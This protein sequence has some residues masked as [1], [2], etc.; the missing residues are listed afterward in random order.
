MEDLSSRS[1]ERTLRV[2]TGVSAPRT[3]ESLVE[4]AVRQR[5]ATIVTGPAGSG[6][7]YTLRQTQALLE[8]A[9]ENAPL[10]VG[11]ASGSSVPLGAFTG[12]KEL[13][14]AALESPAAVVDAFARRRSQSILLVDNVDLLD[15]ASQYVITQLILTTRMPAILTARDFA[16]APR[17]IH[18]LYDA[19]DLTETPLPPLSAA[20]AGAL[21]CDVVGGELTPR[22]QAEILAAGEGNP[23][24]LREIIR[25]SLGDGRLLETPYGWELGGPPG[26]TPRLAGLVAER[27][28]RLSTTALEA[29][30]VIALAGECPLG[31]IS[32]E[33]RHTLARAELIEVTDCGWLRLSHP[34]DAQYLVSRGSSAWRH[35]LTH[36]AIEVLRSSAAASRADARRQADILALEH[37]CEVE[38]SSMIALAEYALGSF[39]AR[40]ALRAATAV[41]TITPDALPA[42]RIAGLAASLLDDAETADRHFTEAQRLARTDAERTSVALAYARHLGLRHHD[43]T[44]A[45][46]VVQ[47]ALGAVR[48]AQSVAHLQGAHLRWAAVAGQAHGAITAPR[49]ASTH[50]GVM[51]LITAGVSGVISGPLHET[52]L[53]LPRMKEVP[54]EL[55]ALMPGGDSLIELTE[56]M[57]LSYSGDVLATRRRLRQ[58]IEFSRENKPESLG[59]WEYALGFL[60]F[61]S[62]DAEQAYSLGQSAISHLG[63]RDSTGLLPAAHALTAAG[64]IATGR[65]I[66]ARKELENIPGPAANDPKVVM[67]RAWVEAWQAITERRADQG[68]EVLFD[69][70]E[71]LMTA[72]HTYFAGMLAHCVARMGRRPDEAA[73]LLRSASE[74]AGGG[75]LRL[76]ADHADAMAAGELATL[77]QIAADA[78]ELGLV[79]TAA[80]TRLWLSTSNDRQQMSATAARR[81]LLAADEMRVHMPA[82]ALWNA[83]PDRSTLLTEREHLVVRLA[84]DRYSAKEI[85]EMNEVSVNTVTNQLTSAYRKLGVGSRTELRDLLGS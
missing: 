70:A 9:G 48:D 33:D 67:L 46:Q 1:T 66:E 68:A 16:V 69:T 5:R 6:K 45:L 10:I 12:T 27:F 7:S 77:E 40:L 2:S 72:Q 34:L 76:F 56:I 11:T 52:T 79:T 60:E 31:A 61:L 37:G 36:R 18:D 49:E 13:P 15:E 24:H 17:G 14:A 43:A 39:D 78:S 26:Q 53:L 74:L 59:I 85:A 63:W 50:E 42:R 58:A 51:S 3:V 65:S 55:L 71:W 80:D 22:A 83:T 4:A 62:A 20:E 44:A 8:A 28:S 54:A 84:A 19:G 25:G 23:L 32:A 73:E 75:L 57:S 82:M 38:T 29:A 35:E 47:E 64:A 41:L 81:H 30:T 21:I